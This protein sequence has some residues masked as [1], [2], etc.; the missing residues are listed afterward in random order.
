MHILA[1]VYSRPTDRQF[2]IEYYL[3]H[4]HAASMQGGHSHEQN[5]RLSVKRVNC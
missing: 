2:A 4:Y 5:I 3:V 1:E